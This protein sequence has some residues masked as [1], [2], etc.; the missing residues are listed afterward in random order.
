MTSLTSSQITMGPAAQTSAY[1]GRDS[2]YEKRYMEEHQYRFAYIKARIP[3]SCS[4]L[5]ILDIGTTP[6][7]LSL[8][9]TYSN[10]DVYGLDRTEHLAARCRS[11]GV[12]LILADL[13]TDSIP[14]EDDWFDVVIFTEVLEHVFAPPSDVLRRITR[15]IKPGGK[16]I[17]S[18]P[19]I[20][21]LLNRLNLLIGKTPLPDPDDQMKKDWVHG[22]GHLHE[23]TKQELCLVLKRCRLTIETIKYLAPCPQSFMRQRGQKLIPQVLKIGY[24]TALA[25]VPSFRPVIYCEC[26]RLAE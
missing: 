2:R 25:L 5:R 6:F 22:H 12:N 16:L 23:Y 24:Y 20:A 8:K 17:L 26:R 13:D 21:T 10:Y 18:V 14:V 19:N 3:S 1:L 15:K 7:T 11:E 9:R 4:L